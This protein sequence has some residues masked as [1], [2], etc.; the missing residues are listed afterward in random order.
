M[1]HQIGQAFMRRGFRQIR[2]FRISTWKITVNIY[3]N[4]DIVR[5][6]Q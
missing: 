1:A 4:A 3:R 6:A 5:C 2:G